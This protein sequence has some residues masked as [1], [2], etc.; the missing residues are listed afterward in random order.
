[1]FTNEKRLSLL[2]IK[3]VDKDQYIDGTKLKIMHQ[4]LQ[5][6]QTHIRFDNGIPTIVSITQKISGPSSK[7]VFELHQ[8]YDDKDIDIVLEFLE[9][10]EKKFCDHCIKVENG[11]NE[12]AELHDIIQSVHKV[13]VDFDKSQRDEKCKKCSP[14]TKEEAKE[15][16]VILTATVEIFEKKRG[17]LYERFVKSHDFIEIITAMESNGKDHYFKDCLEAYVLQSINYDKLVKEIALER[18]RIT[19]Y[20]EKNEEFQILG[21]LQSRYDGVPLKSLENI[22]KSL[23]EFK[24]KFINKLRLLILQIQS[25]CGSGVQNDFSISFDNV[26]CFYCP[27]WPDAAKEWKTR[28]RKWP[29]HEHI[30]DIV[31][32]GTYLVS[33]QSD[34]G[35]NHILDWR[36]SFSSAEIALA[37]I[38]TRRMKYVYF[39]FKS[40]FYQYF[41]DIPGCVVSLPSYIAKT[42]MFHLLEQYHKSWWDEI[43]VTRA[44]L[45]L[46]KYLQRSL[47]SGNL[48]HYFITDINLLASLPDITIQKALELVSKIYANPTQYF[49]FNS[50]RL[51]IIESIFQEMNNISKGYENSSIVSSQLE[52]FDYVTSLYEDLLVHKALMTRCKLLN[53]YYGLLVNKE[54]E[55]KALSKMQ[56]LLANNDELNP[57]YD[58]ASIANITYQNQLKETIHKIKLMKKDI[59]ETLVRISHIGKLFCKK[60]DSCLKSLPCRST[61]FNCTEGCDYD[62]CYSCYHGNKNTHNHTLEQTDQCSRNCYTQFDMS[63]YGTN[64]TDAFENVFAHV[65]VIKERVLETNVKLGFQE[66]KDMTKIFKQKVVRRDVNYLLERLGLKEPLREG[67]FKVINYTFFS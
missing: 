60:C 24:E 8:L 51:L 9:M 67:I 23:N 32:L 37:K 55:E 30:E 57:E 17:D 5:P 47:E 16:R 56:H 3:N 2:D 1:M 64:P 34:Q 36:W 14:L 54:I 38:R 25:Y 44:V 43:S 46:F 22:K 21:S 61:F 18:S 35:I 31:K 11:Y 41:K 49:R 65:E 12:L 39:I 63:L 48:S 33:K 58:L 66:Q 13:L 20:G 27:F 4:N 6:K 45:Y 28:K 42:C 59:A 15:M 19:D 53:Q 29:S 50:K 62:L 26:S 7:I 10:L 40:M 52:R